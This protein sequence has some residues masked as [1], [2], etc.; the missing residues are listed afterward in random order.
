MKVCTVCEQTLPLTDFYVRRAS[1]DG[2]QASCKACNDKRR[3]AYHHA[4]PDR[5]RGY[6][7][8]A[9]FG[10]SLDQYNEMLVAQRSRCAICR[11]DS[12]GGRGTFHVDH[13]HV[14]GRVRGLLCHGC[15]TGLGLF[16]DSPTRL[17]Q[18]AT[19]VEVAR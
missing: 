5:V 9:N 6:K 3:K 4:R 10:I 2:L 16:G 17:L 7:L 14:T 13:D 8:R 18:A 1:A 11:T 19:Y 15:N 12:P